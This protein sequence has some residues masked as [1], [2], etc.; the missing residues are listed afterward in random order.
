MVAAFVVA[1]IVMVGVSVAQSRI[2]ANQE[3]AAIQPFYDLPNPLPPGEPGQVIR[4]EPMTN[5][6]LNGGEALRVLYYSQA[7]DGQSQVT[8]GLVF[9]P[10]APAKGKR[11]VV[12][13]AHGTTGFGDPC[14]PSRTSNP[15]ASLP[16]V[17]AMINLGWVVSVT[18]YVG[19]G[20][21]GNPYYLIGRSEANDVINSVRAAQNIPGSD[22]GNTYAVMGHSQ[23]G[24]SAVWTAELSKQIAPELT[25]VGV[26]VTAPALQLAPLLEQQWDTTIGWAIGPNVMVSW[27]LV[28]PAAKPSD[29]LTEHGQEV[30]Q[31]LAYEC[32]ESAGVSGM[33]QSDLGYQM[34][35]KNP[36]SS[37]PWAAALKE[38]TPPPP[39]PTLPVMITQAI[40]DGVVLANTNALTNRKWCAAGSNLQSNWLGQLATG[41]LGPLATHEDTLLAAWPLET[42]WIQERF[43]GWKPTPNCGLQLPVPQ[44]PES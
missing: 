25:V 10:T 15:Q 7:P 11:P 18:D 29:V 26:T 33:I 21:D 40:G 2:E 5:F 19:L 42:Q 23:G 3:Q 8:S 44:P 32:L 27:P 30:Y 35:S 4:T 34:F 41:S 16:F 38:Q 9:I 12:A 20:V 24:H 17:Q 1:G 39:P 28:Y 31:K 6:P 36:M 13:Y 14:P 43:D 22:A 37:P